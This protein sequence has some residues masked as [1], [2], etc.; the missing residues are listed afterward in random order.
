MKP[1]LLMILT[2]TLA[3][4][5]DTSSLHSSSNSALSAPREL[6]IWVIKYIIIVWLI[7]RFDALWLAAEYQCYWKWITIVQ[8][9]WINVGL[10]PAIFKCSNFLSSS[11]FAEFEARSYLE[12]GTGASGVHKMR[13]MKS[14][15]FLFVSSRFFLIISAKLLLH[16][17]K[18]Q[19][20]ND[21][22]GI[23]SP[24]DCV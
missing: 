13:R 10:K 16:K 2:Q 7:G 14:H 5:S 24:A 8:Q 6:W 4:L 22:D 1:R 21:N 17:S 23:T 11:G 19:S 9:C 18:L 12:N 3:V 15:P 20:H